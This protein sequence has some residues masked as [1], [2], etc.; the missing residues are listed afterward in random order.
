MRRR[1]SA[2]VRHGSKET[3]ELVLLLLFFCQFFDLGDRN[4][5]PG[6]QC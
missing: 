5:V 1:D 4:L 6:H 2:L 3:S